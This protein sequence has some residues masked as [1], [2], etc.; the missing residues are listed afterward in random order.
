M[1]G[2]EQRNLA[3]PCGLYCGACSIYIAGK[4]G[5]Y[6]RLEQMAG[7]LSEY[8]G[9]VLE[10]RDLTCEGCLSEVVAAHCRDCVLRSCAFEKGY[11][12][13]AECSVFPCQQITDFSNDGMLHHGE[14]LDNI[15]RQ[16]DIGIDA[17]IQ[18]QEA[19]WRCPHCGCAVDWYASQCLDCG[20]T[21]PGRWL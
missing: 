21:L 17:W 5:D 1:T 19:G 8:V 20:T 18:E 7:S 10:A 3:V 15:R 16:R 6:K 12:H 2:Q 11:I 4:R 9:R 13:C 14:V